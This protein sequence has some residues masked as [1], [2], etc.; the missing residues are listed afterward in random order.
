MYALLANGGRK[1]Q[2]FDCRMYMH[3]WIVLSYGIF[4]RA[5]EERC[6]YVFVDMFRCL[7]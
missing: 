6:I 4:K 5:W 2:I 1:K 3:V 7:S